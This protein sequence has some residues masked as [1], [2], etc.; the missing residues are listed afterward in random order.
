M[1]EWFSVRHHAA[2]TPRETTGLADELR[3]RQLSICG[4]MRV[5]QPSLDET[6]ENEPGLVHEPRVVLRIA[7]LHTS[8]RPWLD[9]ALDREFSLE[10]DRAPLVERFAAIAHRPAP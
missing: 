4:S 6:E 5:A 8:R 2:V 1:A 3:A 10:E 9:K 7:L